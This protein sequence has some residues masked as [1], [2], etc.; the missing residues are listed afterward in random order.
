MIWSRPMSEPRKNLEA[1]KSAEK[2]RRRHRL[3]AA[4]RENLK[5]RRAQAKGRTAGEGGE[6][7]VSPHDSAG[8]DEN[9]QK[10]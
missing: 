4:L 2:A 6:G 3:G 1:P 8:I 10:D 7:E 5:R 9:M